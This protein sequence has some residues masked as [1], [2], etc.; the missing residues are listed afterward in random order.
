MSPYIRDLVR[1]AILVA[2]GDVNR[3]SVL[4]QVQQEARRALLSD[5]FQEARRR[6]L[7]ATELLDFYSKE[8]ERVRESANATIW[9]DPLHPAYEELS[10]R[11]AETRN[12][13]LQV[14]LFDG[15]FES[16]LLQTWSQFF[17]RYVREYSSAQELRLVLQVVMGI[18]NDA[19]P[20]MAAANT[21]IEHVKISRLPP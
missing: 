7:E 2:S 15:D 21:L 4:R 5:W 9:L 8:V 16:K 14:G 20:R 12:S 6:Y 11:Y 1:Y 17:V 10:Q 18:G 19:N 13:G 3:G